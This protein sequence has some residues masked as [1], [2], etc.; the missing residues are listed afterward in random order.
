LKTK[1]LDSIIKK[2][3]VFVAID[4]DDEIKNKIFEIQQEFKKINCNIKYVEKQNLHIT[5]KFIGEVDIT[6]KEIIKETLSRSLIE[7]KKFSININ[8]LGC[9]PNLSGP[10]ILWVGI[11]EGKKELVFLSEKIDNELSRINIKKETKKFD[12]H[13]T[14]GRIKSN[15]KISVLKEKIKELSIKN[16]G[17]FEVGSIVLYESILKSTGPYYNRLETFILQEN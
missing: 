2:M 14:I 3:R 10:R 8:S 1:K 11:E 17:S 16:F 7:E 4:I 9:F 13:I 15:Y 12:P 6:K 5:L